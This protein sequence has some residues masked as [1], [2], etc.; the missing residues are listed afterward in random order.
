MLH[1]LSSRS[2]SVLLV[3]SVVLFLQCSRKQEG[4]PN[5][6]VSKDSTATVDS[7]LTS[8]AAS[9]AMRLTYEQ[10]Q[11]KALFDK[12]CAV[13]HGKEGKGDGF[14]AFNLDP[15]PRDLSDKRYMSAF[16]EE[17]LYQTIDLGGRGVSKSPS[18]PSWGGRL[19]RQEIK[20]TLDYVRSLSGR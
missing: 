17:R 9:T 4:H 15:H 18:M 11:G 12:Y 14:N 5:I 2:L 19:K 6:A 8:S 1:I 13:C 16:T 7:S 3:C 10:Q 20:Y